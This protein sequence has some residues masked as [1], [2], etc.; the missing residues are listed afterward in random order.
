MVV[1]VPSRT[2][3]ADPGAVFGEKWVADLFADLAS[4]QPRSVALAERLRERD[5]SNHSFWPFHS[6]PAPVGVRSATGS[7]I[8][9]LDGNTYL[10]CHLG[11]GAQALHGHAPA[12]VVEFVRDRMADS[13]GNGY[14]NPIE[15]ELVDLL[16]GI[17]PH[18]EKFAFLNSGTD[19]TAAAIR[20][21]RA[22][23]GRRMVAKFEGS[24]HGVHD[25]G[26]HNTAFWYHGHP[27]VPFPPTGPDGIR[28]T[29]ALRGIYAADDEL[30]VLPDD[31]E[32]ALEL[33]DRHRDQLACVI[34][35]PAC[36]SFPYEQHSIPLVR[37]V[38]RHCRRDGVPFILDEVLS[39]FRYGIGGA[40]AAHDIPADL[41]C[42]GKVISGL[43]IPLSAVGGR[44]DLLEQAQTS[45]QPA[46][47]LGRK[48]CVQTTHAGNHLAL[49]ASYATLSL[50]AEQGDA[51]YTHNR[52]RVNALQERLAGFRAETGIPLR[53]S[54]FGDFIGSFGF[55]GADSYATYREFARAMNPVGMFLLTLLMRQRGVFMLSTPLL[56]TGGAHTDADLKEVYDAVTDSARELDRHGF[57]F[58]S[59][60]G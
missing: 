41:Y 46:G 33:I 34:A 48:T 54:G 56:F 43:G 58:L 4:R 39:G 55:L 12:K 51:Y 16:G 36:S 3:P 37:A 13:S 23:T 28:P 24:L 20:L 1:S 31:L 8:T 59:A 52:A 49:S 57:T 53:L 5:V 18:C 27:A 17:V 25:L 44:A 29:P 60:G 9:D 19:A 15:L 40:A 47:D 45:G 21:C 26:M 38:A 2:G 22:S 11:F 42:F 14:L 32:V 7:R 6:P 10:D 50:L 35:E 30:L